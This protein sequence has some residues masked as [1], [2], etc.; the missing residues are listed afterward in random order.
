M[1]FKLVLSAL[2]LLGAAPALAQAPAAAPAA[3]P[4]AAIQQAADAFGQCIS[5]GLQALPATVTPEAGS[6]SVLSGCAAQHRV[7]D[8]RVGAMIATMPEA[9]RAAAQG[10]YASQMGQVGPQIA[11]AIRQHRAAPPAATPAH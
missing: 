9:Q 6:A 10:Q 8:Q 2:L 1:S 3:G 4:E 5:T 11:E 7:L